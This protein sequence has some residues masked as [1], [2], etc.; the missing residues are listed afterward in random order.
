MGILTKVVRNDTRVKRPHRRPPC[1]VK[2]AC[3]VTTGGWEDTVR[4]C[5]LSLPTADGGPAVRCSSVTP[6]EVWGGSTPAAEF[7]R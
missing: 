6:S 5:V 2:A 7:E 3:T 1:A 4:L